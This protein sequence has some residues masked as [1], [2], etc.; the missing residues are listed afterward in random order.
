MIRSVL[1]LKNIGLF[2]HGCPN[3][4]IVFHQAT[5]IYADNARGKSTFSA[6]LSSCQNSD[7]SQLA[8]RKTIDISDNPEVELLLDNG[9]IFRYNEGF[10]NGKP[11]NI[12]VF[13]SEFVERNVYSGFSV[14]TDQR[15]KLLE[16]ALGDTIV[17]LKNQVDELSR[18]IQGQTARIRDAENL[19][20]GLASPLGLEQFI[21]LEPIA[22]AEE[23]ITE[24]QRRIEATKNAQN[25]NSRKDLI[26]VNLV[27]FDLS[28]IFDVLLRQ[29]E[30][31]E[32]TAETTV[33]AHLAK[34][35]GHGFENWISQGQKFQDSL[36]CPFCGQSVIRLELIAAYQSYFNKAYQDLK[37]EVA[38]LEMNIRSSLADLIVD[39]AVSVATTNAARIESWKDQLEVVPPILDE[40][41]VRKT[42]S[43][44]RNMLIPLAQRKHAAPLEAVGTKEDIDAANLCIR[45]INRVLI[46]YN[47]AINAISMKI[48]DFK[49]GLATENTKFLKNQIT[50]L[51]A[52]IKKQKPEVAAVCE[53][54]KAA[55]NNKEQLEQKKEQA[56]EQIDAKMH[57]TLA[58][59]Q[60]GINSILK[61][62]GATFVINRLSTDYRGRVGEPRTQYNLELRNQVVELG[63]GPDFASGHNFTT[64]LSESDKRTLAL[65]FFIARLEQDSALESKIVVLDDPMSSMDRNRKYQT[66]RRIASLA[67]KC[68]QLIILSHDAYFIRLLRD[69][70]RDQ[71]P[72]PIT[73][74]IL[75]I[76]RA[77]KNYSAFCECNL[78]E[79]CESDYYRHRRM[80]L[81]YVNGS[82]SENIRDIAKAI[83]PML[84]GYLYRRFP[85]HIPQNLM[86]GKIIS[87]YIA[88]ATSEPLSHLL[89]YVQELREINEYASQFHHD[90]NPYADSINVIDAELL[91]FASRS[92]NIIYKV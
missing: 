29:L 71:R 60:E 3:G 64:T 32:K 55:I 70:L 59:Y 35:G 82:S 87:N 48:V 13:D 76:A 67:I 33:K 91:Q 88:A 47:S 44:V 77:E 69:C 68:K 49:N 15:Q 8:A 17:P 28:P 84:E 78:D 37:D 22:N 39:S 58:M 30:D 23:Q 62:F 81:E 21:S 14:R 80:V 11:L 56:R 83:R 27:D 36:E 41:A 92:L 6:V 43:E 75:E 86:F 19:L 57:E 16:F 53:N 40:G 45:K 31:I 65:A 5:A 2:R 54:Y 1:K 63:D 61:T 85:E 42:L 90:T 4:A 38:K 79:K 89:P 24:Y 9:T 72:T 12:S 74:K 18:E 73:L 7:A 46:E 26:P 51:R 50:M 52:S 20:S 34:H 10:W 66:I 25:L